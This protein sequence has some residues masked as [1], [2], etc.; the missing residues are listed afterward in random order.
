MGAL[1]TTLTI[2]GG[3]IMHF[4]EELNEFRIRDLFGVERDLESLGVSGEA[5]AHLQ[6]TWAFLGTSRVTHS[7]II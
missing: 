2:E 7:T 3:G 6:I 4:E 1:I 5:S